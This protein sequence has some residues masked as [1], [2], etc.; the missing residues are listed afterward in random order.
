MED[1]GMT[2]VARPVSLMNHLRAKKKLIATHPSSK[3][4]LTRRIHSHLEILIATLNTFLETADKAGI[5][6]TTKTKQ[7]AALLRRAFRTPALRKAKATATATAD[8]SLRFAS[9]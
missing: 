1:C 8:P 3:I 2:S 7:P 4:E 9:G 6:A 5:E